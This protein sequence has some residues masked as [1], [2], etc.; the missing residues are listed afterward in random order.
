M[1]SAEGSQAA[2]VAGGRAW[3]IPAPRWLAWVAS[4]A[5]VAGLL[6]A[7]AAVVAV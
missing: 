6:V 7:L 4:Y 3:R 2:T 1:K 5:L